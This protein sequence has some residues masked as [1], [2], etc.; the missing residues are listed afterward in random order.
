[1]S[2][3]LPSLRTSLRLQLVAFGALAVLAASVALTVVGAAQ[4]HQLADTATADVQQLNSESLAQTARSAR[5]LVSTQVDTVTTRMESELNVASAVLT[6]SGAITFGDPR[7]W[8][9]KNQATGDVSTVSLARLLVGGQDLGQVSDMTASVPIVDTVTGLLGSATTV[10]QRINDQGDM[11][12]VAT[13]VPGADGTRAIGTY[14]GATNADG[15]PNAVVAALLSGQ[16]YYGTASVVGVPYVTAYGPLMSDGQVVGAIFV[17]LPQSEVDA[18]LLAALAGVAVGHSG[19]VTVMTDDG[20]WVVPPPGA[21]AGAAADA[22]YSQALIDA[23]AALPDATSTTNVRVDALSGSDGASVEVSRYAPWGWTIAAWGMDSDLQV[24][25]TH[26]DQGITSLTWTLMGVG[27]LVAIIA[28]AFIVI[29]SGRIVGRVSRLT[30]ALGR[31][32]EHDLS[33][34]VAGEGRDEIGRM[35]D[36]LGRTIIA[37]RSAVG[38][39]RT[40]AEAVNATAERLSGSSASLQ[41]VA[42]QTTAHATSTAGTATT[43]STEVQSV[44]AAMTEMRSTIESVARDVQAAT[45][46]TRTAVDTTSAAAD[47]SQRLGDSS[48][49]IAE[50][51]KAITAIAAQTNLLALN[52][53]IEAARAGEAGKGFAVVAS[54]VK[55]LAQQTASAIE[56]IRPV[57]EEVAADSTEVQEAVERVAA[58]IARV[59]E[60][61]SSISAAIE[62]QSV[63]TSEIERNL[64]VAA[65][66]A[67][68][69]STAAH[70]L[71]DSAQDAQRSA[72]EVGGAV[73]GL[74]SIATDL[75]LGVDMFTLS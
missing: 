28:V 66:G 20:S 54:E 19:F 47:I 58:S 37:M 4:A 1:M 53:T 34:E 68:E 33:V 71:S 25:P 61:Q 21:D 63:T 17:G 45:G 35:G 32:A 69:I 29:A 46:E 36:A 3:A 15:T 9:A 26:L 31:V 72:G 57:L 64:V 30:A 2:K 73:D 51:L 16:P 49:R 74:T 12:R 56:T 27:L 22:A 42:A 50:V 7:S 44:T 23:G 65:D 24:V 13:S 60:H 67:S 55:D 10:F 59:D 40:G 52:A 41:G 38:S 75:A 14:I 11:L 43:M 8:E 18:P 5:D 62:Q 6:S 70:Q 39:I 48:S